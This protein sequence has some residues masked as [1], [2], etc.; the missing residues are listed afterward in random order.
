MNKDRRY[1]AYTLALAALELRCTSVMLCFRQ[2][3]EMIQQR[4][5]SNSEIQA[6]EY[7]R[8][9][10]SYYPLQ[11]YDRAMATYSRQHP[12]SV[13]THVCSMLELHSKGGGRAGEGKGEGEG[14]GLGRGRGQEGE[15][16]GEV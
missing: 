8:I 16:A 4:W 7:L 14:V 3:K 10:E 6:L 13:T 11:S 12:R 9:L 1:A 5:L 2:A 15:E